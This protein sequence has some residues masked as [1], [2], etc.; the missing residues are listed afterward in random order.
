MRIN[1]F[2]FQTATAVLLLVVCAELAAAAPAAASVS[3]LRS[4]AARRLMGALRTPSSGL[5]FRG[6]RKGVGHVCSTM[7]LDEGEEVRAKQA[8][9]NTN[10]EP[11][12]QGQPGE[13]IEP[14]EEDLTNVG[15]Y[16]DQ[17]YFRL[18]DDV[19]AWRYYNASTVPATELAEKI[20]NTI[21]SPQDVAYWT[22]NLGRS[23]YFLLNMAIGYAAARATGGVQGEAGENLTN[24]GLS[25]IQGLATE[26]VESHYWNLK[27]IQEGDFK[28]PYDMNL[29]HRQF[30]PLFIANKMVKGAQES[31]NVLG[32]RFGGKEVSTDIWF[33]NEIYPEY[34]R[35]TFHFQTDG[36]MS[37]DSA[38][39]YEHSTE[40]LFLGRQDAMQRTTL[41]PFA[42]MMRERKAKGL[43]DAS[44]PKVLEIGA[45]TGRFATFLKDSYPEADL[46][47]SEL[48]PY[49]LEEARR[50]FKHYERNILSDDAR[51]SMGTTRFMQA[52]AEELPL[53]DASQDCVISVYMFHELPPEA[54]RAVVREAARV[55]KPGG[56]FIL[57]DSIQI[58][59]RPGM[60]AGIGMFEK[61]NEPYYPTFIRES[62]GEMATE[63]GLFK[64]EEKHMTSVTKT[65]SFTRL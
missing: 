14:L 38:E 36:W 39:I 1:T 24:R 10:I 5:F 20:R 54:R 32:R 13:T 17:Y 7:L 19:A 29:R 53:E 11:A 41:V 35:A 56:T 49:Y 62:F 31:A 48:S 18:A 37:Q 21:K 15:G 43:V 58:G 45:G 59:D 22:Y 27:R 40:T 28:M 6:A 3:P 16:T 26:A 50:N 2:T 52:A 9:A 55:L 47:V 34:Y 12:L 30:N 64:A 51:A 4:M 42:K 65:L 61:L 57:T 33:D 60:D 23:G 8:A 63:D 44:K 25:T 46:I